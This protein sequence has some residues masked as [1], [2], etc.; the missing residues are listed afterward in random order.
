MMSGSRSAVEIDEPERAASLLLAERRSL[1]LIAGGARLSDIL[2]DICSAIDEQD[3]A[4]MSTVLLMDPDGKRLWPAAPDLLERPP[5][6]AFRASLSIQIRP[7]CGFRTSDNPSRPPGPNGINEWSAIGTRVPYEQ[8][9]LRIEV[10]ACYRIGH[11][12]SPPSSPW[13]H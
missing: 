12:P 11:V 7:F 8:M 4:M 5:S 9:T 1:E 2:T 13:A 3:P 6:S 10:A